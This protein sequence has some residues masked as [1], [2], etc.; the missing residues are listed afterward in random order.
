MIYWHGILIYH[1]AKAREK[2]WPNTS[3][4][5]F[6]HASNSRF[7][8]KKFPKHVWQS[9]RRFIHLRNRNNSQDSKWHA[10]YD[11]L[12]KYLKL[13]ENIMSSFNKNRVA[14]KGLWIDKIITLNTGRGTY[15]VQHVPMKPTMHVIKL[16][17]FTCKS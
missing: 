17:L 11:P 9:Y 7:A 10:M 4:E 14:N 15:F 16:F 12:C 6:P 8:Q 1:G 2:E 5:T 13:M 3:W